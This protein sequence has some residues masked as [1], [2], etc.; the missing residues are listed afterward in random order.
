[1]P[2]YDCNSEQKPNESEQIDNVRKMYCLV[3]I[4]YTAHRLSSP[5]I[6]Y[7]CL[8]F[9]RN[10]SFVYYQIGNATT[11]TTTLLQS[12]TDSWN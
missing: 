8:I 11:A 3:W 6:A 5:S 7:L 10:S 1:M 2:A 12:T 9:D 4:S